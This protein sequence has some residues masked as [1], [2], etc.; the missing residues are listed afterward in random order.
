MNNQNFCSLPWIGIHAW[1]DGS[2]FPCCMYNSNTP[3]GNINKENIADLVNNDEYKKLRQQLLNGEKPAGCN[4]C[5][6]L[7]ESGVQTLRKSTA[8]THS[9]YE[10]A[11][12]NSQE[13]T[14]GDVKY[15]DVRFSNICNFKC[16][17]CGPELSSKWGAEI[18]M[19]KNEPDP[20]I[21][22]IPRE[23]F[24]TY[25][26]KALETA[27]EIVFAGGEALMQEEHYAALQKLI[28]LKKFD[29]TLMYTTNLSTLKYKQIDLFDIWK[30][31]N[32]VQIYASLDASGE[33][34]EYLRKGTVWKNIVENRKKIATLPGVQ[35]YI[36][37]TISLFN[38]WHFP[39]FYK[40]WVG[41]GLLDP[42]N[43][44]LNILTH[45]PR[46]QA[47]VLKN[48]HRI[49]DKWNE[50]IQWL[51]LIIE[52]DNT[53]NN[54]AQQFYSVINFLN[55]E[56]D[57]KFKLSDRFNFVNGTVDNLRNESLFNTF[58]E[59][60]HHLGIPA[61]ESKTF[62]IY[63]FYNI[64]SN[65]DGSVKLCCNI[66]DNSHVKKNDGTEYNLGK[67]SIDEIWNSDYL[68]NT[69]SKMLA[70][71]KV[72]DCKDCYRHEELSGSS[73]RTQS[74]KQYLHNPKIL[75]AV[76]DFIITHKVSITHLNSVELR[77]GNVCNLACNSCW[78][79]SS[80]R[81]N[82][83]RMKILKQEDVTSKYRVLWSSELSIPD[84]INKWYKNSV[85]KANI[86]TIAMNLER[87]YITGGEPTLIKENRT[88]LQNLI[89]SGNTNC[90]ISFTTNGTTSDG[91]LLDLLK[92]FTTS[93]IQI[94]LDGIENQAN[95][96]RYPINWIEFNE[97]VDK[98]SSMSNVKIVFY[99]VVSAYNLFSIIDILNYVDSLAAQRPISWY[100][101]F[102]DNPSFLRTHIWPL[103]VRKNAIEKIKHCVE[104]LKNL[105]YY[106]GTD[107]FQ[108][109]YDYY[110]NEEYQ[111]NGINEFIEFNLL[112]DKHRSTN[113]YQTFPELTCLI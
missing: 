90:F 102:L 47:N 53:K 27:D 104:N 110:S 63:P 33:R 54:V 77:L 108:K 40:E 79:Y 65:T 25:Y 97:N 44:R 83:E 28:E 62:C 45:P 95:Y 109:I 73:S 86:E 91:E 31:F 80:S 19:L 13:L 75:K 35:F 10:A 106:V 68:K 59:L 14:M 4:R 3:L 34:A 76:N 107:T 93:E 30:K 32:K 52:D 21:I 81:V 49:I 16:R 12:L 43:I 37:P 39:D 99:T 20:G 41:Q 74:N 24:W 51:N 8:V 11:I 9:D 96:I 5:Y 66:R 36:T 78:G 89:D 98:L 2:V 56:P 88:L 70:G 105:K 71:E 15:L 112:L 87:V 61:T 29:T 23:K 100:P 7:E 72:N 111:Y 60:T 64:N 58:P 38:V 1:P 85:Y 69:R 101:I 82:D 67:D 22:Q 103:N 113:F 46:Q 94:S 92:H 84:D 6:Q 50:L 17:T 48:K 18:P 26:E 42:S 57:T 55:T